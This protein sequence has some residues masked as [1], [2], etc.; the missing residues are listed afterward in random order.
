[1]MSNSLAEG[2]AGAIGRIIVLEVFGGI[3]TPK[4]WLRGLV[5]F[6]WRLFYY[7]LNIIPCV[8]IFL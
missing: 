4:V 2:S 5:Q 6:L 1:M 3:A 7:L 8:V